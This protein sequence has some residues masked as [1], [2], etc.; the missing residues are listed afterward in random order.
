M[1]DVMQSK[2]I[3]KFR[4]EIISAIPRVP[5][6]KESLQALQNKHLTDLLIVFI[7]WQLSFIG[8]WERRVVIEDSAKNDTRWNLLKEQIEIFLDKVKKV[9][10]DNKK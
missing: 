6:N 3:K 5:N 2:R 9:I 7:N 4:S 1:V 8:Q 10:L